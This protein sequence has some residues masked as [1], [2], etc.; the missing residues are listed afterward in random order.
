MALGDAT[1]TTLQYVLKTKYDQKKLFKMMYPECAFL[2]RIRKDE[3]FGGNNARI[4]LRYGRP[5]GGS[6]VFATA[7]T[8]KSSSVDAGFLLT[9]AKDYYVSG[10]S[11]EALLAADGDENTVFN[12]LKG[13]M[14]GTTIGFARSLAL[15]LYGNGGG[16]R[17]Q[18]SASSNTATNQITLAEPQ[19]IVFFEVGMYVQG[20]AAD[21]TS[22]SLRNAGAHELIAAVDRDAGKLTSTSAA[23]N[24]TIGALAASDYLFR[25]GDF[26]VTAKG[27]RGWLPSTAPTGGDSW[28][29]VD[30]SVDTT[31]LAG[32]RFAASA[33]AAKEDTLVDCSARLGREGG[34]PDAVYL[35]N[36]DRA[37]IVKNLMGK[38]QYQMYEATGDTQIAFKA[39]I[40]EGDK[41]PL[42][43]MADPNCPKGTFFLLQEDTWVAKSIKAL[44]HLI[45]EDGVNML[46]E[47]SADGFEWRYRALWQLG[48]EAPGFN[49][50]GTF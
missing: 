43:L 29:G 7:Q 33:G 10:I 27:L 48:C 37:D 8:N 5:Q 25:E 36:L 2:A 50:I 31:R 38:A 23:W 49:A 21:G 19:N 47:S 13:E 12:G 9:R 14:E 17:G 32:V 6:S 15:A 45:N 34:T 40:L 41:G 39:L 26:G 28:F 44:P 46:R 4:T 16:A 42:R 35:H 24:T 18:I 30:R 3:K 22:G 11:A 1:V 20:S